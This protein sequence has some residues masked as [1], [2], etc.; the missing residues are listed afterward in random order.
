V[1]QKRLETRAVTY[2]RER[3][4]R[5]FVCALTLFGLALA[6]TGCQSTGGSLLSR[7]TEPKSPD[8]IEE[9]ERVVPRKAGLLNKIALAGG[10]QDED[11]SPYMATVAPQEG[12]AEFR[13]AV[14]FFEQNDLAEAE[15]RFKRLSKK[16][17][18]TTLEEDALYMLG[19]TQ[20]R[21][22]RYPKAQDTFDELYERFPTNRYVD[23]VSDRMFAIAQYWLGSPELIEPS[24]IQPV[25]FEKPI[26]TPR[27]KVASANTHPGGSSF[28]PNFLDST[29]PIMDTP[30]RAMQVLRSIWLND[31]TGPK[32]DDALMLSAD[33][34]FRRGNYTE[35]D[36]FY[37]ILRDEYPKSP[38]LKDAFVLGSHVKLLSYQGPQYDGTSLEEARELKKTAVRL[39]PDIESKPRLLD[40]IRKSDAQLAARQWE[41][42]QFYQRKGNPT[43]VA[44]SAHALLTDFP[45]SS[46]APRAQRIY[47]SLPAKSKR[48]LKPLPNEPRRTAPPTLREIPDEPVAEPYTPPAPPPEAPGRAKL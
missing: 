27:P 45:N 20:F 47:N 1:I 41:Q 4:V 34:N 19:E 28:V 8:E 18:D 35:A 25:N 16:Y 11:E 7:R 32:A 43:A 48:N 2:R 39:F 6:S 33:Y 15:K 5:R 38:Y 14:Q 23:R 22:K 9:V 13:Q 44:V 40:E 3:T 17:R 30:G 10:F 26:N 21:R 31:P 46:Y 12:Q 37:R 24:D 42:V 29:R 36:R